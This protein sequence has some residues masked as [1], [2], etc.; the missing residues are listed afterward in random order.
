MHRVLLACLAAASLSACATP[1]SQAQF[2]RDTFPTFSYRPIP[3]EQIRINDSPADMNACRRLGE[4]SARVAT[5]PGLTPVA[6]AIQGTPG[7]EIALE[8]M[9]ERTL[10]LG[11]TDLLLLKQS[12]DWTFV[13]GVAY[14]CGRVVRERVVVR[15][16]G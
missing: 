7:F 9:L 8:S 1:S 11:G 14:R 6:G 2:V 16:A 4:V 5:V 15:A 3:V 12:P 13:R 10:A